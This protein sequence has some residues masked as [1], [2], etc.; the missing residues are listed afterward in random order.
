MDAWSFFLRDWSFI[1]FTNKDMQ[2]VKLCAKR[3]PVFVY[4]ETVLFQYW[5]N[6][7]GLESY[8]VFFFSVMIWWTL[9]DPVHTETKRVVFATV[10]YR[11][12]TVRPHEADTETRI[13]IAAPKVGRSADETLWG[14]KRLRVYAL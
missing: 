14:A 2:I 7:D 3:A 12:G 6:N 13:T 8:T 10:L 9:L 11:I 1:I 4:E 5:Q